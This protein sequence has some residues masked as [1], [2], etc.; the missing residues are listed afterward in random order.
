MPVGEPK[1]VLIVYFKFEH[2]KLNHP[3]MEH[4]FLTENQRYGFK[5]KP[6]G[7]LHPWITTKGWN[8]RTSKH[9]HTSQFTSRVLAKG[10]TPGGITRTD[11]FCISRCS[12]EGTPLVIMGGRKTDFYPLVTLSLSMTEQYKYDQ[13]T[14]SLILSSLMINDSM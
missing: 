10:F 14:V 11:T 9:C 3:S 1:Q 7:L 5:M 12:G 8:G 4:L 6:L 2:L 13:C